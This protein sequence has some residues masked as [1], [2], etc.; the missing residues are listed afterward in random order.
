MVDQKEQ[1]IR[2][3]K[4]NKIKYR[5]GACR[6]VI[7]V[8]ENQIMRMQFCPYCGYQKKELKL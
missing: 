2:Q 6:K 3:I 5:C 1:W 7:A 4:F 8:K